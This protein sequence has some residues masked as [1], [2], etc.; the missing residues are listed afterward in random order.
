MGT[1]GTTADTAILTLTGP[2]QT[3][4]IDTGYFEVVV[5]FRSVGAGTSAV[6]AGAY[7]VVHNLGATG[8]AG[9]ATVST[10]SAA[11]AGFN[12]T[13]SNIIGVSFNGGASFVGTN[14][15]AGASLTV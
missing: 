12:S 15:W 9:S 2:A 8:L 3:A 11:S 7:G 13:T 5:T 4:A 1:A 14:V 10:N 6:I